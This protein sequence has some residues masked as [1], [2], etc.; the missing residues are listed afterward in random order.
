MI[1]Q[2]WTLQ[3]ASGG[4]T[5]TLSD[6]GFTS[7]TLSSV[8]QG[9]S[10][11]SLSLAVADILSVEDLWAW[12]T[13]LILRRDEVIYWRGYVDAT[14]RSLS[15]TAESAGY[16]LKNHWWLLERLTYRQSWTA[17]R[18]DGA[19][20][21]VSTGRVSLGRAEAIPT[22]AA[23][24]AE[25][26][27]FAATM[28]I[29]LT[30]DAD[31]LTDQ[32][33]PLIEAHNRTVAEL[34]RDVL[35]WFP[36]ATLVPVYDADGTSYRVLPASVAT[37][38]VI[39]V[40]GS[41][42]ASLDI[43]SLP[44]LQVDA[45]QIIYE[46]TAASS[47]YEE[48]SE[49]T[50]GGFL[51]SDALVAATD[52]YPVDATLTRRS[53]V[54]T[55]PH[56]Q[57]PPP[58]QP[59]VTYQPVTAKVYPTN[60]ATN[61]AAERW[62]LDKSG[63]AGLGITDADILL[64]TS[65]NETTKQHRVILDPSEP[66][67]EPP[68]TINPNSTPV[69]RPDA[70]ADVPRELLS[71]ALADWMNV[72]A[73]KLFAS[74]TIAIRKSAVD[75][76]SDTDKAV[77][78]RRGPRSGEVGSVDVWLLDGEYR[79]IGT[80]A[81]T[82]VYSRILAID[83]GNVGD[84]STALTASQESYTGS[85]SSAVVPDLAERLYAELSP[86][87]YAG[88]IRLTAEEVAA[89]DYLG[90]RITLSHVDR[91]E[92][93]TMSAMVQQV[94]ADLVDGSVGITYGPPEHLS[95]QDWVALHEAARKMHDRRINAAGAPQPDDDGD[96]NSGA[97]GGNNPAV[98]PAIFPDSSFTWGGG[99]TDKLQMWDLVPIAGGSGAFQCYAPRII[100]PIRS[101]VSDTA[102]SITGNSFT[103]AADK[104]VFVKMDFTGLAVIEMA[105]TWSG[106]PKWYQFSGGEM[107]YARIPLWKLVGAD[108]AGAVAIS[109]GVWALRYVGTGPLKS[110]RTTA[111]IPG[112]NRL[113]TVIDLF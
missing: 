41:P 96:L 87:R 44:E 37:A 95:P 93:A 89:T 112:D 62:W 29:T 109:D 25:L 48:G 81:F 68:G 43:R 26:S 4:P 111:I 98:L 56:P 47:S 84:Y 40:G 58:P 75:A 50:I 52:T 66:P 88:S 1:S 54:I 27:A 31:D 55:L 23:M 32:A 38:E 90:K 102:L 42:L 35:R 24:F 17:L 3:A 2:I 8:N 94:S 65:S 53:L 71:G 70:V 80:D 20:G 113:A 63:L 14:P 107:L 86:L 19:L 108:E 82:R 45:V 28:G 59:Q 79:F 67:E 78:M 101:T 83:Y 30:I 60:N 72:R 51:A 92:W 36:G 100:S 9:V 74:C 34:I 18:A 21:P 99:G 91:P 46:T 77:F 105:S 57:I 16:T 73:V 12:E 22:A 64:P 76:L 5:K 97:S 13:E 33:L 6:W 11:L 39:A 85:I 10:T 15:P 106:H 110:M 104:W 61:S 49:E 7:A 69:W 103:P